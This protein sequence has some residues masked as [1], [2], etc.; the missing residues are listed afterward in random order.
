M[1]VWVGGGMHSWLLGMG[2]GEGEKEGG[3]RAAEGSGVSAQ[4]RGGT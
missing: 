4:I 3:G 2:R 1:G